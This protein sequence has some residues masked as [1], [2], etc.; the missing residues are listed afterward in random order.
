MSNEQEAEGNRGQLFVTNRVAK[1]DLDE[2]PSQECIGEIAI[3]PGKIAI[4]LGNSIQLI[5]NHLFHINII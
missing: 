4:P 1:G 3:S 5:Y 2:G